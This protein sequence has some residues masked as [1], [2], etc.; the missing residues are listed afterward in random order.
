MGGPFASDAQRRARGAA[1]FELWREV[2]TCAIA[3]G[4]AETAQS[5]G[6]ID[7]AN[8][9]AAR[10]G[11]NLIPARKHTSPAIKHQNA[12]SRGNRTPAME[13]ALPGSG[14]LCRKRCKPPSLQ[15]SPVQARV[16]EF[17]GSWTE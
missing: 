10:P 9:A 5:S 2:G 17:A 4:E 8:I 1:I 6:Q 16:G 3:K 12:G 13:N 7:W 15:P 11:G 14:V